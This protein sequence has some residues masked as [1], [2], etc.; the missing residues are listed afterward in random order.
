MWEAEERDAKDAKV[1][2]K[3][4]EACTEARKAE[5]EV[6]VAKDETHDADYQKDPKVAPKED[7]LLADA[8]A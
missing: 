8:N 4:S 7:M 3:D 5:E 6:H 1:R 2:H